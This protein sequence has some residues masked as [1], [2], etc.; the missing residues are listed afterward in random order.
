[1]LRGRTLRSGLFP[2]LL[3]LVALGGGV[4][5]WAEQRRP[6][7]LRLAIDLTGALPGDV[8][9][10]DVIVRRGGRALARHDV[11]Y[12]SAGAPA[13]VEFVVHAAPGDAEV[14]TSLAYR[15]TPSHRTVARVKLF[16]DRVTTVRAK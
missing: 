15:A 5:L 16:A 9:E 14:E 13:T 12:G 6:R 10:V 4:L 7:D 8:T 2:R 3:L 1:M 11:S